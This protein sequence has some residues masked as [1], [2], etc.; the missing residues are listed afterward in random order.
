MQTPLPENTSAAPQERTSAPPLWRRILVPID[1][2]LPSE[3]ALAYTL[4]IA[5]VNGAEVHVCHVIPIPHVLDAFYERGLTQPENVKRIAQKA[6]KRI[7]EIAVACK[8]EIPLRIRLLE[9]EAVTALLEY[10]AKL[11]P[12]LI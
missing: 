9:G 8:V 12:D 11:K 6:R 1:F 10:A 5:N 2:S 4:R 3:A 7:K